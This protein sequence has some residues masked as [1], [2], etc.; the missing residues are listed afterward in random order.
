[1]LVSIIT[2]LKNDNYYLFEKLYYTIKNQINIDKIEWILI[3]Q[4]NKINSFFY[5]SFIKNINY[6][7]INYEYEYSNDYELRNKCNYIATGEYIIYM[8]YNFYYELDYISHNINKLKNNNYLIGGRK[9]IGIFNLLSKKI[10]FINIT[11]DD[12]LYDTL[13]YKKD[14]IINH[15]FNIKKINNKITYFINDDFLELD[16]NILLIDNNLNNTFEISDNINDKLNIY[17]NNNIEINDNLEADIIYYMGPDISFNPT[18]FNIN[19][20]IQSVIEMSEKWASLCYKVIVYANFIDEIIHNNVKYIKWYKLKNIKNIIIS[21]DAIDSILNYKLLT[22]NIIIIDF[23]NK[24]TLKYN[25]NIYFN[26][27]D[28]V[29]YFLFYYKKYYNDFINIIQTRYT[30]NIIILYN[31]L[32]YER[33]LIKND[34][35]NIKNPYRYYIYNDNLDLE[36]CINN[37]KLFIEL[38]NKFKLLN[39]INLE[40]HIYNKNIQSFIIDGYNLNNYI[41]IH[42]NYDISDII[43][44]QQLSTFYLHIFASNYIDT[45]N[46]IS[47]INFDCIPIIQELIIYENIDILVNYIYYIVTNENYL[48]NYKQ[49]LQNIN[50]NISWLSKSLDILN[51]IYN[52]YS[53]NEL[54]IYNDNIFTNTLKYIKEPYQINKQWKIPYNGQKL[55][56]VIIE[57]REHINLKGV[58][59]QMAHIYGNTDVSLYIFHGNKNINFINNIIN[60]W[61]NVLLINMKIDNLSLNDYNILLTSYQFWELF[62]SDFVLIF[63][64]DSIIYKKIPDNFFNYHYVGAPWIHNQEIKNNIKFNN[65][66]IV[67]NG[68]FSLR[69]VN[70]MINICKNNLLNND[71]NEDVFF[72]MHIHNNFLPDENIAQTF[73]IESEYYHDPVGMH[74]AW[75]YVGNYN[76]IKL[77]NKIVNIYN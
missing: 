16:N 28:K 6:I 38:F 22:D 57:P 56:V 23:Y 70:I 52:N 77:F 55:S 9:K 10:S 12:Y 69:N 20:Y 41:Y 33:L 31:S 44:E 48:N 3:E 65:K 39:N 13:I 1:M 35:L 25:I 74:N 2:I 15:F 50:K 62:K 47:C 58:L 8:N 21:G 36:D 64:V 59:Y 73:S 32:H 34:L 54:K 53:F 24:F 27:F 75:N 29:N 17:I 45:Y 60:N 66:K 49:E 68:G 43:K 4:N 30:D 63:Q 37:F 7:Y 42:N 40:L 76:Y 5:K 67:G 72:S 18:E 51:L 26:L 19:L 46:L 14:Y 11:K 71:I 61:N